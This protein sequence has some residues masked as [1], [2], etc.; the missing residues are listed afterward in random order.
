MRSLLTNGRV[1]V[2]IMGRGG[3]RRKRGEAWETWHMRA[4]R[5]K[6]FLISRMK[7]PENDV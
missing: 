4:R 7:W 1:K 6:D 5:G 2:Q 3:L